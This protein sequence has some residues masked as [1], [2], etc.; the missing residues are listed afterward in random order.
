MNTRREKIVY[1]VFKLSMPKARVEKKL[2]KPL[3]DFVY[4]ALDGDTYIAE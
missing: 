4:N 3:K 1:R 2:F